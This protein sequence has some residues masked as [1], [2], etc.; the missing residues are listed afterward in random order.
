MIAI[1]AILLVLA[2]IIAVS[3]S[4][5]RNVQQPTQKSKDDTLGKAVVVAA[6]AKGLYDSATNNK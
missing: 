4:S 1:M 3:D 5:G 2:V 6:I